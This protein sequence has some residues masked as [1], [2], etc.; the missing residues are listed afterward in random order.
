ML[1]AKMSAG[2]QR[3][4]TFRV[5]FFEPRSRLARKLSQA[6][7]EFLHRLKFWLLGFPEKCDVLCAL[8]FLGWRAAVPEN[9]LR[10]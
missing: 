7:T 9:Y 5:I 4:G 2:E 6:L 10:R 3:H 8:I 1:D